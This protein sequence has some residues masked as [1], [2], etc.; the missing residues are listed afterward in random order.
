MAPHSLVKVRADDAPLYIVEWQSPGGLERI[1]LNPGTL[2]K[3][4][5][6]IVNGN[7]HRDFDRNHI[8]NSRRCGARRTA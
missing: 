3:G 5:R 2:K 6:L 7:P 4:E 8:S 1:G